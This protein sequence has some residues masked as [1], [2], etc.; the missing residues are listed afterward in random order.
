MG[1]GSITPRLGNMKA[2]LGIVAGAGASY[3]IYKLISFKRNKKSAAIESPA[4]KSHQQSEVRLQPGSL[5]ARV[6][7]LDVVCPRPASGDIIHQSPDN[8]EP[9]HLKM[10][11][12]CLQT[13]DNPSDRC[14]ILLTVGNAAAFTV[15]QNLIREFEGIHIIAGFLS[16]PAAEVRVQTL[17][18]LNN[19]CMNIQNQEQI[20]IYVPQV[21]ELIEVSP[22]NSD[23]QLGALRLLTNLSVSDKHQHLLKKSVTLLLSLLVVSNEALQ[24]QTLKVLVNLSSNPDMMD[25]IVQAQAPASVVLLFDERTAPAVLLRLLTF[26]GNLKAWR[27][28]AQVADELRRKQDC[29]FRVMLD[30]SSQLH[31]RLVQLLSHPDGEIQTQVARILT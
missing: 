7:G 22:V 18:A 1:D 12:S 4:V 29:L 2:L 14:R 3:G 28:S 15:N 24:V 8:L 23:L 17:N 9:Q 6:S 25:D 10:L 20:K 27:P 21:L 30:E 31:S 26:A 13:S 16:D 5:L 11:L 19:L